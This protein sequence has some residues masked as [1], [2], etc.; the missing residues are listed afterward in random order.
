MIHTPETYFQ[1]N[2]DNRMQFYKSNMSKSVASLRNN[3]KLTVE[4]NRQDKR[5]TVFYFNR[6][7]NYS[8]DEMN[9]N[10]PTTEFLQVFDQNENESTKSLG[11]KQK[12]SFSSNK[13][14]IDLYDEVSQNLI[15]GRRLT[16]LVHAL[17]QDEDDFI[18]PAIIVPK[19]PKPSKIPIMQK[20][21]AKV[22]STRKTQNNTKSVARAAPNSIQRPPFQFRSLN[23]FAKLPSVN[24]KAIF[25]LK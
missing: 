2:E 4:K 20:R 17:E 7:V 12:T 23:T 22:A 25:H 9:K 19:K 13:F 15:N 8:F 5:K 11:N 14:D 16:K 18:P 6:L 3:Y 21:K 1:S 24:S 10:E